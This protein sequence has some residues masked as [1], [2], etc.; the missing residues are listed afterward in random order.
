V[1]RR[2]LE[3]RP[4]STRTLPFGPA[5]GIRFEADA[6]LSLDYWLGLCESELASSVRRFCQTGTRCV[7]VGAYNAYYALAFAKLT[8]ERVV[9]YEPDP[10]AIAR[11][12][13]NLALNPTLASLIDLRPV[14][15]GARPGPGVV[16]LDA[17][18]LPEAKETRSSPWLLKIDVEGAELDVLTGATGFLALMRPHVIVET[19]SPGLEDACGILLLEAGYSPRVVTQRKVLPQDRSWPP[20]TPRHNRWLVAN[21]GSPDGG[22]RSA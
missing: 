3:P 15:V 18:L 7:D 2:L 20:G 16:T 13:R 12:Q 9:S 19:H 17:E 8:R 21:G 6:H 4:G 11:S 10:D 14:A 1:A 5:S 22:A